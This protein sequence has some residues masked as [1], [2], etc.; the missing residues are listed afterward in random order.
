[1]NIAFNFFVI[2]KKI[3]AETILN[4]ICATIYDFPFYYYYY[5]VY[6]ACC[7]SSLGSQTWL[8][9]CHS[10]RLFDSFQFFF[11]LFALMFVFF[12]TLFL[13]WYRHFFLLKQ[14]SNFNRSHNIY[15]WFA[16]NIFCMFRLF[17]KINSLFFLRK[18]NWR[19][20]HFVT[21]EIVTFS[22]FQ[23]VNAF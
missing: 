9:Q 4:F 19:W 3:R 7:K 16:W 11:R 1:M 8:L 15:Y 2:K 14:W 13:C 12:F 6:V 17:R 5:V 18:S 21:Y 23:F 22:D 10:T 20:Y